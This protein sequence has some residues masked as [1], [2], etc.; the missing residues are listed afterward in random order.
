MSESTKSPHTPGLELA[1]IWR[2]L[3]ASFRIPLLAFLTALILGAL[4]IWAASGS[5]ASVGSAYDG[6]IRGALIKQRGFSESLVATTPYILLALGLAV[7]FK[8]GLFNIGA[9]GQYDIG[10][11]GAAWVGV[12]LS[13]LGLPAIIFL[14]LTLVA[15]ALCGAIWAGFAGFLKAKTG[16]HEVITTM[17]MNYIAFRLTDFLLTGPVRLM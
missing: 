9:E 16:A 1:V 2:Q 14:P 6:L 7:G 15:G 5:L 4:V 17:M 11:V 13:N 12:A 8:S 3:V 10:A